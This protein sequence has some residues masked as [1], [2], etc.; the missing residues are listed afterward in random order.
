MET[1]YSGRKDISFNGQ[2]HFA[3]ITVR[4]RPSQPPTEVTL[5]S[6]ALDVLRSVYGPEFEYQRHNVW[7]GVITQIRCANVARMMPRVGATSFHVEVVGVRVSGNPSREISTFLLTAAAMY[8]IGNY[9]VA[10][11]ESQAR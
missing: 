11:E 6:D 9:L 10:W 4:A 3:E 7:T 1:T 5:T 2:D 8:A